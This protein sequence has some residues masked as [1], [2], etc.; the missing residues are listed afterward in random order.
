M[1]LLNARS[2]LETDI[3]K[4]EYLKLFMRVRGIGLKLAEKLYDAG[5]RSIEEI[6]NLSSLPEGIRLAAKYFDDLQH[7]MLTPEVT[8]IVS[9]LR[10]ELMKQFKVQ[11]YDVV[12][13]GSYRRGNKSHTDLDLMVIDEELT[14]DSINEYYKTTEYYK[15]TI[16]SGPTKAVLLL[17]FTFNEYVRVIEIY[18]GR[19]HE[20]GAMLLYLTGPQD[21]TIVLRIRAKKH[22][23]M[24]LNQHGL[25]AKDGKLIASKTEKEVLAALDL[26]YIPPERRG[27][28]EIYDKYFKRH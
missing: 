28:K 12:G 10:K 18:V 24:L 2:V 8:K 1:D 25:F 17:K 19:P 22:Y 20:R 23:D 26:P 7:P 16:N 3:S 9:I 13:A 6:V 4:E 27:T 21:F 5:I 15:G 11:H 14:G